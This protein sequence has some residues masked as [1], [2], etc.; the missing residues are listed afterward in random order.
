M[1]L[2]EF[3]RRGDETGASQGSTVPPGGPRG[4]R[5]AALQSKEGMVSRKNP[6]SY[7]N[8]WPQMKLDYAL[9]IERVG[10]AVYVP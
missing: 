6:G 2:W 3:A 8:S 5:F 9:P 1:I 10:G 7:E 4:G